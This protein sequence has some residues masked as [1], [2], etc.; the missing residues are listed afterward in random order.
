MEMQANV[1]EMLQAK[2]VALRALSDAMAERV[3]TG[4][5][6]DGPAVRFV[7]NWTQAVESMIG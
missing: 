2:A 6:D 3:R 7:E 1:Q 5:I 4:D